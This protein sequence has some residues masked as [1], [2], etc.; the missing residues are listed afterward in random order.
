MREPTYTVYRATDCVPGMAELAEGSIDLCVT[1]IPFAAL[2]SYSGKTEDVGNCRD[3][4]DLQDSQ[5]GLNMRFV[6][7]Q[8]LRVMAPGSITAIHIQ[9]LYTTKV[10]HGYMGIRDFR[11]AVISMFAAGGYQPHGE[12]AIPKNPQAVAQRSKRHSLL[13]V[14]GKRDGRAL[15][16]ATN[17]HILLFRKPGQGTPVPCLYDAQTNP[18]GWVSTEQWIKWASGVWGDIRETDVVEGWHDVKEQGDERHVCPIQLEPVRRLI[19]IYSN[20]GDVVLDPFMGVGSVGAV[21]IEQGRNAIGYEIKE[22]YAAKAVKIC[23]LALAKRRQSQE[24]LPLFSGLRA[25]D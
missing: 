22:S 13:F 8:L 6:I 7:S 16:P 12:V 14:T 2:F 3:G 19:K 4:V 24:E 5:F 21:A 18:S 20:P 9:Q 10:Q 25:A 11:G 17:D 1:S 15:A 23:E